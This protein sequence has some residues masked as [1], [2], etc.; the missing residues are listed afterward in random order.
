MKIKIKETGETKDLEYLIQESETDR[1][2]DLTAEYVY[3]DED[4]EQTWNSGDDAEAQM[5]QETYEWWADI[6]KC[7]ERCN[8]MMQLMD[9]EVLDDIYLIYGPDPNDLET[10]YRFEAAIEREVNKIKQ[11]R[12]SLQ[13]L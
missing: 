4:V 2:Q 10:Y 8:E 11:K 13:I 5:P 9:P 12:L 6:F 7:M 3:E 1:P